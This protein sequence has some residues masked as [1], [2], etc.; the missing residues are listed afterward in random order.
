MA[1]DPDRV[2]PS[3]VLE[4]RHLRTTARVSLFLPLKFFNTNSYAKQANKNPPKRILWVTFV[5]YLCRLEAPV[6]DKAIEN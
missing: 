6:N 5:N 4:A 1:K 3:G 2:V